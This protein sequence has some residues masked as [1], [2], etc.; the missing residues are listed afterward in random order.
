MGKPHHT[1]RNVS[2]RAQ[3]WDYGWEGAY[4]ITICTKDRRHFFGEIQE[5]EMKLSAAG[6]LAETFWKAIPHHF[7]GVELGEFVIMPDHMHGILILV[8]SVVGSRL[9]ATPQQSPQQS[10]PS[11]GGITGMK[12]PML[13]NNVSRMIRWYKGRCSFEIRKEDPDF[14]WQ[15]RFYDRIIRNEQEYHRISN[16]IIQNPE[17][18]EVKMKKGTLK[19]K[20]EQ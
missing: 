15:S 20:N 18:W 1:Y 3:W 8:G 14:G 7:E 19:M 4:F 5:G 16:Y 13:H 2:L 11:P 10:P 12:N 6:I 9:I 17:K